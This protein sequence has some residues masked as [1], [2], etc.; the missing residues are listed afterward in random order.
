LQRWLAVCF[1]AVLLFFSFTLF[2]L[3]PN[4][5][6]ALYAY[7]PDSVFN[8]VS[9][10]EPPSFICNFDHS[11]LEAPNPS[12]SG[13]QPSN[14]DIHGLSTRKVYPTIPLPV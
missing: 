3:E 13:E 2:F 1:S 8:L 11:K 12:A 7:K 10:T 14:A 6:K 4:F 9:K 5:K